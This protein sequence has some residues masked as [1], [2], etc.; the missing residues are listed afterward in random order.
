MPPFVLRFDDFNRANENL[1]SDGWAQV[2]PLPVLKIVSNVVEASAA[3]YWNAAYRDDLEF[4]DRQ[5][6]QIRIANDAE[7]SVPF[8]R[9]QL[10]TPGDC[11][12]FGYAGEYN[13]TQYDEDNGFLVTGRIAYWQGLGKTVVVSQD[14]PV[15]TQVGGTSTTNPVLRAARF[16]LEKYVS[17]VQ[18]VLAEYLL[19]ISV[20][21]TGMVIGLEIDGTTLTPYIDGLRLTSHVD[22]SLTGGKI[23][24][25]M[26]GQAYAAGR[27]IDDWSGGGEL[28]AASLADLLTTYSSSSLGAADVQMSMFSVSGTG[29]SASD[30]NIMTFPA[31]SA[32]GRTG[33]HGS[34]VFKIAA[35]TIEARS[36]ITLNKALGAVKLTAIGTLSPVASLSR[37]IPRVTLSAAATQSAIGNLT[38]AIAAIR[39]TTSGDMLPAATLSRAIPAVGLTASAIAG[40]TGSLSK[41]IWATTL[42]ATSH[43]LSPGELQK[44]IAAIRLTARARGTIITLCL[45]T[46]NMALTKYTSFNFNSLCMFNGKPVGAQTTG[47]YELTGTTDDGE[48]IPWKWKAGYL[49]LNDGRLN[50]LWLAGI[51]GDLILAVETPDGDRWEYEAETISEYEDEMR[52]KV[53]KGIKSRFVSFEFSPTGDA[54]EAVKFN[55][56]K[57]LGIKGGKR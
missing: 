39:T 25:A 5:F 14:T 24:C 26:G 33:E 41:S 35:I 37:A 43:W 51:L 30:P 38:A 56:T 42:D 48:Q 6:S 53:G 1:T 16:T 3:G 11:Y 15:I 54:Q 12:G 10:A 49:D 32:T 47:I 7:D 20:V 29:S 8:V 34:G 18:T 22:T 23:G 46:R 40:I 31:F 13:P 44:A 57:V 4:G 9:G 55:S 52:I 17:G 45:N 28:D 2:T 50:H 36:G 19:D 27:K 21:R